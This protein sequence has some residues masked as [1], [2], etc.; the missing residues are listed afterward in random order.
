MKTIQGSVIDVELDGEEVKPCP[1][2]GGAAELSHTWTA[3]Y[4]MEC[5]HCGA[6]ISDPEAD[7]DDQSPASH[8]L[9]AERALAAWNARV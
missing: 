8:M 2:C 3:C 1:F 6:E 4:W 7:G 9:S 5:E